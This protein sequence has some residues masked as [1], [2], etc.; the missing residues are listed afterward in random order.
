[1]RKRSF[2]PTLKLTLQHS[3]QTSA[4]QLPS[5]TQWERGWVDKGT[6]FGFTACGACALFCSPHPQPLSRRVG[7]GSRVFPLA[8]PAGEG[9]TGGEGKRAC[10][11]CCSHARKIVPASEIL[12]L[13]AVPLSGGAGGEGRKHE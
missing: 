5:P 11:L 12:Y 9:D 13:T 8:R 10:V 2:R 7:E 1:V 6:S 4:L 3:K